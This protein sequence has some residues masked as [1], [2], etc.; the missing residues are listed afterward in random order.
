MIHFADVS[1]E[2]FNHPAVETE[3]RPSQGPTVSF[4]HNSDNDGAFH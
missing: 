3:T 4:G 2:A 1:Y